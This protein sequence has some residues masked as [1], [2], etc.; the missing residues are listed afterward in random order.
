MS[1]IVKSILISGLTLIF[2]LKLTYTIAQK[3]LPED[4]CVSEKEYRL[5]ELINSLR[6]VS[7]MPAI[8]L[9][10]SMTYVA[11]THAKD[12]VEN[13]PDTS[14]C[15]LHSWSDKGKW[16]ACCY[17]NYVLKRECMWNKPKEL[18]PYKYRG[19]ELAFASE[20]EI[21]PDSLMQLWLSI[22]EVQ[23][24]FLNK[25]AYQ[26]K[27]W[28]AVGVGI[29]EGYACV[30]F[31]QVTDKL[32]APKRC[33]KAKEGNKAII[34]QPSIT[35]PAKTNNKPT[36]VRNKTDRYYLIF[37]SYDRLKEAEKQI[38][39][40]FKAGFMDAKIV[41]SSEKIRIS[42]SDHPDLDAAKAAKKNLDKKYKDAWIIK[43]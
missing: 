20:E 2:S 9:S 40:Y 22:P 1:K 34:N 27:K 26:K 23:D 11:Q 38:K 37:G 12:L 8:K 18:T 7:D 3:T 15:N 31:G 32:K 43:F 19:Y 29:K 21:N 24:M 35:K 6:T 14:I 25:G 4:L 5:Y 13:H 17:Q 36:I 42:L 33:A 41:I 30:W 10:A 16:T 39:R 28:L